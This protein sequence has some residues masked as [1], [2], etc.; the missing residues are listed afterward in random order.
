[1]SKAGDAIDRHPWRASIVVLLIL[2]IGW[3]IN[4]CATSSDGA[5][6]SPQT[7]ALMTCHDGVKNLLKNPT[8]ARFSDESF[9]GSGSTITVSGSV[10]AE[11]SIGGKVT[12]TYTCDYFGGVAHVRLM[13]R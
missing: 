3:S 11:N 2:G 7:Y 4:S 9:G 1:M 12:S 10:V 13:S 8:T 5:N 6:I